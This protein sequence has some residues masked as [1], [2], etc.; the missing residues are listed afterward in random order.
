MTANT[1]KRHEFFA[2]STATFT[3]DALCVPSMALNLRNDCKLGAWVLGE[4]SYGSRLQIVPLLFRRRL[5]GENFGVI[6]PGTPLGE[7]W[8]S[9]VAGGVGADENGRE[10]KLPTNLV[11]YTI[12]KNSS[13][14]KSGSLINFGQKAV[15][16]QASGFDYRECIWTPLFRKKSATIDGEAV[17][18]FALDFL[19][20]TPS[21]QSEEEFERVGQCAGL[22]P[23]P[24]EMSKLF[25]PSLEASTHSIDG[26]ASEEVASLMLALRSRQPALSASDAQ[27]PF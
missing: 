15:L 11:Y 19:Y 12:L 21:E 24:N 26:M 27:Q 4:V 10:V 9:V 3:P 17:S 16:C 7:L 22:L 2:Q 5:A 1:I 23:D 13:S 18:Y 14:G 25:D 20:R 8:F 6:A